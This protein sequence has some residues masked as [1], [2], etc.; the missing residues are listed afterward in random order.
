MAPSAGGGTGGAGNVTGGGEDFD[1]PVVLMTLGWDQSGDPTH[2]EI[3]QNRDTSCALRVLGLP[4][5]VRWLTSHWRKDSY[6]HEKVRLEP[7]ACPES[8][9]AC[10]CL[11]LGRCLW[12]RAVEPTAV[13]P[14]PPPPFLHPPFPPRPQGMAERLPVLRERHSRRPADL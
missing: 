1:V 14:L 8:R 3:E 10:S 13:D 11:L 9:H 6:S 7:V 12:G 5:V 2:L 4:R